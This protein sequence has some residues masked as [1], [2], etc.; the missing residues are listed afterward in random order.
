MTEARLVAEALSGSSSAFERIVRR[1]QRPVISLIAR[2]TGDVALAEELAQDTFV[3]AYRRLQAFDTTRR[4]S[5]WLF[6]IAHNTAIDALRRA[7]RREVPLAGPGEREGPHMAAP[8][9]SDPVEQ[10]V[11]A[12]A[13]ETAMRELRPE[14][15]A[16]LVLR[17]E[18]GL[19]FDEIGHALGIPEATARS[20]VHR[21][22]K[23]MARRLAR[24]GWAPPE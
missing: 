10:E 7:P 22:R 5:S 6:R 9:R 21:A 2:M 20:H 17:Y 14:F 1:Y 15:R 18:E 4:L 16:A 12:R 23:D 19:S 13:L 11:L 3:K 8:A 24:A